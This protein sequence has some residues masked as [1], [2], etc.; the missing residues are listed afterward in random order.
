MSALPTGTITFLFTD[1]EGSTR[2]W[3]QMP[4]PMAAALAKHDE[5]LQR[6][7]EGHGGHV[8][9]TV[10]DAFCAAFPKA[11]DAVHASLEIHRRLSEHDFAPVQLKVRMAMHS[12]TAEQRGEDYFGPTLN[13]TARILAVGHGSQILLSESCQSLVRDSLPSGC[14]LIG[15]G[16]HRLRD[17][18]SP[19]SIAQLAHADLPTEFPPLKSLGTRTSSLPLFL[20]R[21]IGRDRELEAVKAMARESRLA[22]LTGSGGCGKTRL[23]TQA[24]AELVEQFPDGVWFIEF[25]P[26]SDPATISTTLADTLSIPLTPKETPTQ[27]ISR[28]VG[29]QTMMLIFDNCEHVLVE[30][31]RVADALLKACPNLHILATSREALGID[32]ERTYRVPSMQIPD[33]RDA[34]ADS[35]RQSESAQLF[36]DRARLN[37]PEFDIDEESAGPLASICTRLDGIPLAIELA[38]SRTRVMSVAQIEQ[39]LD[40]RFRLLT[41]G[42]RSAL[43]RQQTLRSLID[44]SHDLL[45]NREKALFRRLS[46]FAGSW[47]MEAAA[48]VCGGDDL[49]SWEVLDLMTSLVDKN[50]VVRQEGHGED[51]YRFL[52]TIRQYARDQLM[53]SGETLKFRERHMLFFSERANVIRP[54]W[55]RSITRAETLKL[56]PDQENYEAAQVFAQGQKELLGPAL[57]LANSLSGYWWGVGRIQFSLDQLTSC[58][59]LCP[60]PSP[61]R[62]AAL[63]QATSFHSLVGEFDESLATAIRAEEDYAAIGDFE[64]LCAALNRKATALM[65]LN[66]PSSD[67]VLLQALEVAQ[68]YGFVLQEAVIQSNLASRDFYRGD[69]VAARQGYLRALEIAKS[70]DDLRRIVVRLNNL[71]EVTLGCGDLDEAKRLFGESLQYLRSE[72][73]VGPTTY[74]LDGLGQIMLAEGRSAECVRLFACAGSLREK[75]GTVLP[76]VELVILDASLEKAKSA[77]AAEE[78]EMAWQAGRRM[79][80]EDSW[81]LAERLIREETESTTP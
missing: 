48:A 33:T 44:W 54:R 2:Q 58:I 26:L 38:A 5:I 51:R 37:D 36:M 7:I 10:G 64:G 6:A 69:A 12:G 52:E 30:A 14:S 60:E 73:F 41:G 74:M 79:T 35:V 22:S 15:L 72:R 56:S 17:L 18:G 20:S 62:A 63:F 43:P 50:L 23:A 55:Q 4:E 39:H 75:R 81:D 42:S 70:D 67:S 47:S 29:S 66:V 24:A 40:E 27:T 46:A 57:N 25:A 45:S 3:E 19:E 76:A 11:A 61:E 34:D 31:A 32:G 68:A 49:E 13:R 8:F 80:V 77:L 78:Y 21:F 9:K 65:N 59:K 16:V 28:G 71:A 1:I 53:S